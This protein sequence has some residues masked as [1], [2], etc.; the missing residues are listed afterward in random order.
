M[1]EGVSQRVNVVDG[2]DCEAGGFHDRVAGLRVMMLRLAMN[3]A[4]VA[5][6]DH[7]DVGEAADEY[8]YR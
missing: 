5:N 4:I 1:R 6:E 8:E 2:K 3:M 7:C